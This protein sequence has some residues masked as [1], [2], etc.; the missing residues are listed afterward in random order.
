MSENLVKLKRYDEA[1][2]IL[3][4]LVL[5]VGI[6]SLTSSTDI[7]HLLATT[8]EA[9]QHYDL[10]LNF[11]KTEMIFLDSLNDAINNQLLM[12][13]T[14]ANELKYKEQ[15]N[16]LVLAEKELKLIEQ[17]NRNNLTLLGLVSMTIVFIIFIRFYFKTRKKNKQLVEANLEM[18]ANQ[19]N[20]PRQIKLKSSI[21]KS[22]EISEEQKLL[23]INSL[24]IAFNENEVF[25]DD[26]LTVQSLSKLLN[27]NR[28]YLTLVIKELNPSGFLDFVNEYRIR[29][30]WTMLSNPE[31]FHLT[32]DHIS[33]EV[34]FKSQ[35][36]FNKAFKKFTGVTP[37]FYLKE[38]KNKSELAN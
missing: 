30:S 8:H 3:N 18:L 5:D 33:K 37:S 13:L 2:V 28:N 16:A 7:Y 38:V 22:T 34:G 23:I 11:Y 27:T 10:A 31:F 36:T 35:P 9:L 32:I 26:S 4:E 6:M 29:K 14:I 24:N 21:K 19:E 1:L 20:V 25:K 12:E 15:E 17:N